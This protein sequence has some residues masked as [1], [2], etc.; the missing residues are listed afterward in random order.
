M[1]LLHPICSKALLLRS[2]MG[3]SPSSSD[4]ISPP[5]TLHSYHCHS[6]VRPCTL[7]TKSLAHDTPCAFPPS[8]L[9]N[10]YASFKAQPKCPL[11][12]EIFPIRLS[13]GAFSLFQLHSVPSSINTSG[14]PMSA[15][16]LSQ[17]V[18]YSRMLK[19]RTRK[20][21]PVPLRCWLFFPAQPAVSELSSLPGGGEWL[22]KLETVHILPL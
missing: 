17:K 8:L 13:A 20:S 9:V 7:S 21:P 2:V 11:F 16:P 4:S 19:L 1:S 14:A 10:S 18:T 15:C 12:Y 6:P 5:L 22:G 3:P